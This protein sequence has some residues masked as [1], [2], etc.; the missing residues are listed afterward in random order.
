MIEIIIIPF[1][2]QNKNNII[3]LIFNKYKED[4]FNDFKKYFISQWEFY[5]KRG[6]LNYAYLN[7]IQRSNSYIENYNKRIKTELCKFIYLIYKC[8]IAEYLY[9][10]SK[11]KIKWPLFLKFIKS[12]EEY[13]PKR[14]K[15]IIIKV[16][17]KNK[18]INLIK[19]HTK[20]FINENPDNID[21][22]KTNNFVWFK[23]I[24]ISSQY[25]IF[26]LI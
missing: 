26:F 2:V 9:G 13:Y 12:V 5:I 16:L 22:I 17:E 20:K 14:T 7:K 25:D 19:K 11:T 4:Y 8:F 10:K 6:I 21:I 1:K 23:N 3:D 18:I 15:N 24:H